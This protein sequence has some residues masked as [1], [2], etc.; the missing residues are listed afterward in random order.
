MR[1]T[2]TVTYLNIPSKYFFSFHIQDDYYDYYDNYDYYDSYTDYG[3]N[4][5]KI[6]KPLIIFT[7]YLKL[8]IHTK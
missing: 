1:I 2:G 4:E 8:C 5:G 3:S 6:K 7:S